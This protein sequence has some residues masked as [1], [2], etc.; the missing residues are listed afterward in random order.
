MTN[1][2]LIAT[3]EVELLRANRRKQDTYDLQKAINTLSHCVENNLIDGI[4]F[5][6]AVLLTEIEELK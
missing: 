1:E 2:E 6:R 3:A 5:A 4:D